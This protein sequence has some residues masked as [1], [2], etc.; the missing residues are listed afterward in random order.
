MKYHDVSYWVKLLD[1]VT[2]RVK[3]INQMLGA[4]YDGCLENPCRLV[5]DRGSYSCMICGECYATF[6]IYDIDA[7]KEALSRISSLNDGIWLLKR[8]GRLLFTESQPT[9]I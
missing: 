6:T 4:R 8:S 3:V 5:H 2:N 1:L 7:T 9:A